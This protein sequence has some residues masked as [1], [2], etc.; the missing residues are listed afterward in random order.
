MVWQKSSHAIHCQLLG[1]FLA[2][3]IVPPKIP[4]TCSIFNIFRG[5]RVWCANRGVLYS[6]V[7]YLDPKALGEM[8]TVGEYA[9]PE[10]LKIEAEGR[11]WGRWGSESRPPNSFT[12]LSTPM[13]ASP[14]VTRLLILECW[15][16]ALWGKTGH[17]EG[18]SAV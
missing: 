14:D 9:R 7:F 2:T 12:L 18:S 17:I 13:I 16:R 6:P 11:E 8:K 4:Y 15:L 3:S 5:K 10:E 1:I